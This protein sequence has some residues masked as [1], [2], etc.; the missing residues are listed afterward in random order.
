MDVDQRH[1]LVPAADVVVRL[2]E[3]ARSAPESRPVVVGLAGGVA[4]G[5]TATS[6]MLAAVLTDRDGLHVDVVSTDGFLLPNA[7]LDRQ[8]LSGR[9]GFPESYD[10]AR[11]VEF[12]ATVRGGREVV[13]PRYDHLTYDV[14]LD[15]GALVA[16][17]DVLVLEGVN[18]L[19]EPM[20]T[21]LDLAIYLHA[22]EDDLR[23]WYHARIRRLRAEAP[24]DGSS[25]YDG[26]T[27]MSDEEFAVIADAVWDS[28][29]GPNLAGHIAPTRDLA[30]IV[31]EKAAD[32]SIRALEVRSPRPR[33]V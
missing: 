13:A 5:K 27:G 18:A 7:D 26:F 22:D 29:N 16:R 8:G 25:F 4:V 31:I 23:R 11:L 19:Q 30:D 15:G 17:P 32:H 28:V 3:S 9:K 24:G 33:H 1:A 12:V 14:V 21:L 2:V 6:A 10:H 20:V